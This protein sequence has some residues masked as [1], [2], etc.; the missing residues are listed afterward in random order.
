MPDAALIRLN[1]AGAA[2]LIRLFTLDAPLPTPAAI[3]F[4]AAAT[5]PAPM[6]EARRR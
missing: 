1:V 2:A 4:D 6:I 5:P 3:I